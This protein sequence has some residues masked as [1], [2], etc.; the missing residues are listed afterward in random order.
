MTIRSMK[1]LTTVLVLFCSLAVA[2]PLQAQKADRGAGGKKGKGTKAK[3]VKKSKGAFRV[4]EESSMPLLD[5]VGYY[6]GSKTND[7]GQFEALFMI[8]WEGVDK[9]NW[10]T[11]TLTGDQYREICE[12]FGRYHRV[13]LDLLDGHVGTAAVTQ[14]KNSGAEEKDW[15][16]AYERLLKSPAARDKIVQSGAT[17]EQVIEFLKNQAEAKQGKGQ[18][19]GKG[20]GRMA[21][22]V[23]P[24]AR[25]GSVKFYS[26]VIGRLRSKDIELGEMELDI[27]YVIS[28]RP[29]L[30]A[31]L[32][33]TRVKLVGV[34]GAFLDNLLRIKRGQTLKVRTGDYNPKT[35][36]L[37]FGYKFQVLERTEP[38][39]PGDFGVPP[40]EFRGFSGELV[41]KIVEAAGYE[42]LLAVE[43]SQPSADSRAAEAESIL[44]NRVRIAGFYD[45]HDEAFADL[46]EGD[47]IRVSVAHRNSKS[48]ALNVTH[49]LKRV[50]N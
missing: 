19:K 11:I 42:V 40:E 22:N 45:Q 24:G 15:N 33:G 50:E 32:I 39:N 25:E 38:F 41:G 8:E 44:G 17:K 18:R 34:A 7:E 49:L 13:S 46:H 30:N 26:I 21:T 6:M 4:T 31:D 14:Q 28:D 37:G 10:P 9:D 2:A 35:K 20:K 27:D 43:E 23:K 48:D 47:R 5:M 29:Q 12:G 16:A 36:E 3:T 1:P